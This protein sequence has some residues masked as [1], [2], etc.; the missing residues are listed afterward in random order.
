MLPIVYAVTA[1]R[2]GDRERHSYVVGVYPEKEAA[3]NAADVEEG[4][5]GGSYRSAVLALSLGDGMEGNPDPKSKFETVREL[6]IDPR[7]A[8]KP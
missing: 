3:L 6:E 1:Y 8:P 2:F 5:R 7:F 4:W